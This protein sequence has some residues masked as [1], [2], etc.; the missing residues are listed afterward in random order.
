MSI[1][2][3]T[4]VFV[5]LSVFSYNSYADE[6]VFENR[7]RLIGTF[8]KVEGKKLIFKSEIAG[9][10]SVDISK[11]KDIY[12]EKLL[13][14]LLEDGTLLKGKIIKKEEGTFTVQ[15]EIEGTKQTFVKADLYDI[16]PS[17][18][19]KVKL[20]GSL[21]AG[22]KSSHGGSY[23]EDTAVNWTFLLRSKKHRFK[24]GG[25]LVIERSE[26]S[27]G[28]KKTTEEKF[29]IFATYAYFFTEKIFGYWSE[30]FKK[31]HIDDLDYRL[32][33]AWGSGYQWSETDKLDFYTFAGL[34]Y[35]QEKYENRVPN[36]N[37]T[38][39]NPT[40]EKK[41]LKDVSRRND[42]ILQSGY[43][44]EW[45]PFSKIHYLSN[46]A[47]NPSIDDWGDYNI[48]HDSEVRTFITSKIYFTFKFILDYDSTPGKGSASTDTDYILGFGW[49][50]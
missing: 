18:K 30:R 48:T 5:C 23:S 1:I 44:I 7:E 6:V 33:S 47:Y 17:P 49:K 26:D 42:I 15:E 36:P 32:T 37:Y 27:D 9:E 3:S 31:D 10:I 19:P 22:F 41:W 38:E 40:R 45:K 50:F 4:I 20:S 16:Y 8:K 2:I 29:T 34:G 21:S 46:F 13:E 43:H 12:S 25:W 28:E 14:I 11:I 39:S 35:L 24:Q